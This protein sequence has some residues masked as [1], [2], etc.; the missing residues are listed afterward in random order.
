LRSAW[1]PLDPNS[2]RTPLE[3]IDKSENIRRGDAK[4]ILRNLSKTLKEAVIK[5][6]S[7][8]E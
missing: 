4:K 7:G 8:E 1:N 3:F 2:T 5:G 6:D